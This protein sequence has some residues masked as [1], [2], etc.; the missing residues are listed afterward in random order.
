MESKKKKFRV[1]EWH[2]GE[3]IPLKTV[4]PKGVRGEG[5]VVKITQETAD[6]MNLDFSK[7][8]GVG[9]KIKYIE[10]VKKDK[11]EKK[12]KKSKKAESPKPEV[13]LGESLKETQ[14]RYQMVFGK[15][16]YY[17]WDQEEL[18]KRINEK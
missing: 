1:M 15:K 12:A 17:G 4:T 9:V 3:F 16:A 11:K 18:T 7:V 8:R 10:E 5:K 2:R 13:V 14:E 6:Q